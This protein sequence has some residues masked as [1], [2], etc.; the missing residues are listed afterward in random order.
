MKNKKNKIVVMGD[1]CINVLLWNIF[2]QE[3]KKMNW[4]N[5]IH[6]RRV[7]IPGATFL[8]AKMIVLA[9]KQEV[10]SPTIPE[11]IHLGSDCFL[12]SFIEIKTYPR[13]VNEG[14]SKVYRVSRFMGVS[15]VSDEFMAMV[16]LEKDAIDASIV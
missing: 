16:P 4:E 7:Y 13:S 1:T 11:G 12:Y 3:E 8:L 14:E 9:T 10:I 15:E 5:N 6:L 2:P